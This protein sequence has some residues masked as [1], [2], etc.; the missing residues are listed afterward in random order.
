M[1]RKLTKMMLT[2][3]LFFV[4]PISYVFGG[5]TKEITLEDCILM[6][7]KNNLSVAIEVL[8]P[9]LSKLSISKAREKFMPEFSFSFN[10]RSTESASYSF[11]DS[12]AGQVETRFKD[13]A[14]QI[15]QFLPTG[16]S[17]SLSIVTDKTD[18]NRNFQTINPRFGSTLRFDFSQPL[19]KGFGIKINRRE[20]T[21]ARNNREI[22][23]SRFKNL[24]LA[25]IYQVENAYWN[26][27]YSIENLKVKQQS[28]KLA[29]E[30]LSKNKKSV[31]I[32][33]LAP[34]EIKT[35][36]AEV[37]TREA[38]ILEAEALIRNNIDNLRTIINL[39]AGRGDPDID[40]L[41]TDKPESEKKGVSLEEAI[42]IAFKERPDLKESKLDIKNKDLDLTYAKNQLM[43]G[44]DLQASY[45][46]PGISG[47]RILYLDDNP[48]TNVII[49][50]LPGKSSE[51][52]ND[53]LRF[54]YNNWSVSL[55]LSVPL[56]SIISRADVAQALVS[57]K[58]SKLGLREKEQQILLE[59]K[60][61]V[62]DVETNF[63]RVHAYRIARELTE[64]KLRAEEEKLRVGLS[65]NYDLL[66][67]QRDF[68]NARSSELKAIVDY[69]V[70]LANQEK[71]LGIS[72]D[73]KN[74][75]MKETK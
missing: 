35:A 55:V 43:P 47:T 50:T 28:L 37:A 58:Q 16:G 30:L 7:L 10:Q 66:L 32:G 33:S 22:T 54:L 74:I 25:T 34:I 56:S 72:L 67:A 36:E 23:L 53:A 44:L 1:K 29:K 4:L 61:S 3:F 45:W 62:R 6:A 51:S 13:Y 49:G 14:A 18:T 60:N 48:L 39:N 65:T 20:I 64:E 70:S 42:R 26:L 5:E 75:R 9:E 15:S 2:T 31:E 12:A 46:S 57:L 73:K 71:V 27:V 11:L 52:M 38:D 24:L 17:L 40:I 41:P 8:N 68:A 63:K 59:I 19:L 21:V 69:S